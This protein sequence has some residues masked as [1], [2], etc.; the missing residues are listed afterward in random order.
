MREFDRKK[1]I[2]LVTIDSDQVS[3]TFSSKGWDISIPIFPNTKTNA[4]R[5]F[6]ESYS[7]QDILC[8]RSRSRA[9]RSLGTNLINKMEITPN[10]TEYENIKIYRLFLISYL[11]LRLL[12]A[13]EYN[14]ILALAAR[15]WNNCK[16]KIEYLNLVIS[17]LQY[18]VCV[19]LKHLS[20]KLYYS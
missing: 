20:L 12:P 1:S 4:W 9:T 11:G 3:T 7:W 10:E 8:T 16:D 17:L 14:H 15:K 19:L 2:T 5:S 6:W 18:N 13:I